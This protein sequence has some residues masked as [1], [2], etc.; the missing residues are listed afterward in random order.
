MKILAIDPG[1]ERLGI[2]ILEKNKGDQKECVVY[3][4]C[5]HTS[6][7]LPMSERLLLVGE[8]G[9]RVIKKYKPE[10][11]AHETLLMQN[12]QKTV[13]PVAESR[14]VVIYEASR[15]GLRVFEYGP[16]QI[17]IAVAGHGRAEKRQVM[18][19]VRKLVEMNP[20]RGRE[21]SQ[22]PSASNGTDDELD[23]VACGLTFFAT[24]KIR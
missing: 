24:E 21:G 22:R 16:Q 3:S 14:G 12:N 20:V 4:D 10:E 7:N 1:F 5:F 23:A 19:M 13:M 6:K 18:D 2:A 8:K 17:K 15:A 11:L 9:R